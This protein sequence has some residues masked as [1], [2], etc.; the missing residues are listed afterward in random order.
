MTPKA[1][2]PT[3]SPSYRSGGASGGDVLDRAGVIPRTTLTLLGIKHVH[4]LGAHACQPRSKVLNHNSRPLQPARGRHDEVRQTS[5]HNLHRQRMQ[6]AIAEVRRSREAR[7]I[8]A[9]KRRPQNRRALIYPRG[10]VAL[11]AL[12]ADSD[13]AT[14]AREAPRPRQ[15]PG[16]PRTATPPER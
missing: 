12:A 2:G 4:E 1:T 9:T 10:V 15:S 5:R 7:G 14:L 3:G 13:L 6:I 8:S 16:G 11:S